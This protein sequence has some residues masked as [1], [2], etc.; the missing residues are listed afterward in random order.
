MSKTKVYLVGDENAQKNNSWVAMTN[1]M[2]RAIK[3]MGAITNGQIKTI[4]V[5]ELKRESV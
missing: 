4:T 2:E 1:N 5:E 3:E